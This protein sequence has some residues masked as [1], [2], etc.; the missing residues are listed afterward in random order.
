MNQIMM[1]ESMGD[2]S[3]HPEKQGFV[4]NL[5]VSVMGSESGEYAGD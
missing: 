1:R 4:S 2:F 5:A 3:L